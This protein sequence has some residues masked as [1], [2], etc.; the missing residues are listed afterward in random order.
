VEG[1]LCSAD[2]DCCGAG[3]T[4]LPGDGTVVCQKETVDSTFGRCGT[5]SSPPTG[6][7]ACNPQG[8]ICHYQNY[9]CDISS[10]RNDCCGDVNKKIGVCQL[11]GLG[12]PRCNGLSECRM[13]GE[14]C[15]SSADCC[16]ADNGE[17]V[18]C[19][20][21][22]SGQLVCSQ[23]QC[24]AAGGKCTTTADCCQGTVCVIPVGQS[25]GICGQETTTCA[26]YG[27]ACE[28]A[29]D[30]CN[31]VPCNDGVCKFIIVR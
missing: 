12:I 11:D 21:N 18:L 24:V 17:P 19:L 3:G 29:A 23:I 7:A 27:Q 9:Y 20:P 25:Q 28:T 4:G 16:P 14:T 13:L 2:T 22:D 15:A 30:C 8:D 1:E 10:T 5:P 26:E 31:D 6:G